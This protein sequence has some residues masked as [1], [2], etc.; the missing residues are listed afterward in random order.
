M[1]RQELWYIVSRVL[2]IA[3]GGGCIGYAQ[4]I[5][6]LDMLS[7]HLAL[8][9]VGTTIIAICVV[10]SIWAILLALFSAD[11]NPAI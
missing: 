2:L 5:T 7:I 1:T 9:L 3:F 8:K 6:S 4:T 10:P 11:P